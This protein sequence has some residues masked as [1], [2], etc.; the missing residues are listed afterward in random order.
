MIGMV[1]FGSAAGTVSTTP[2]TAMAANRPTI[3]YKYWDE[4]RSFMSKLL[5]RRGLGGYPER[6]RRFPCRIYYRTMLT[7][8]DFRWVLQGVFCAQ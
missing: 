3:L 7:N 1:G 6:G 8:N 5:G 4:L 2:A